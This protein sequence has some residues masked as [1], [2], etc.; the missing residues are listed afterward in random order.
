MAKTLLSVQEF[1]AGAD[2]TENPKAAELFGTFRASKTNHV[3]D[4]HIE[5]SW[6]LCVLVRGRR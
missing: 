6:S 1:A 2:V 5:N 3:S 4:P